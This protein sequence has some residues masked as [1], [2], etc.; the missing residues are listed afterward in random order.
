MK[1]P[2]A[3]IPVGTQTLRRLAVLADEEAMSLVEFEV[4]AE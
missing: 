4:A 3:S 1:K 2:Q